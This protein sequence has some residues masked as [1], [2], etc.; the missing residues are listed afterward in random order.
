MADEEVWIDYRTLV[1]RDDMVVEELE[2]VLPMFSKISPEDFLKRLGDEFEKQSK[3][4]Q[5]V[6]LSTTDINRGAHNFYFSG[7]GM[8]PATGS[9]LALRERA[10]TAKKQDEAERLLEEQKKERAEL[11]RLREKYPDVT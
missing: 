2:F 9:E 1:F 6:W 11:A 7:R 5:K 10:R 3:G 4:Y 8:R